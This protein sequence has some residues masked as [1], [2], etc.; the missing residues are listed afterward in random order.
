MTQHRDERESARG[1][2]S[3]LHAQ[4]APQVAPSVP[5][6]CAA[7]G[8]RPGCP[9]GCGCAL[10]AGTLLLAGIIWFAW[11]IAAADA[12]LTGP[13]AA[14]WERSL[15]SYCLSN[16]LCAVLAVLMDLDI[17]RMGDRWRRRLAIAATLGGAGLASY[18]A[19]WALT[20]SFAIAED[21]TW[22]AQLALLALLPAAVLLG[23]GVF[24]LVHMGLRE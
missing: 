24:R 7:A 2:H 20:L 13:K 17:L 21:M 6:G 12:S 19:Y 5:R 10:A 1:R 22:T 14:A 15:V 18:W 8:E 16:L 23:M 11:E 9:R 3:A 4:E